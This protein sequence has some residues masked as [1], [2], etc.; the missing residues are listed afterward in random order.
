MI[1]RVII[2]SP[3][4]LLYNSCRDKSKNP[5]KKSTIEMMNSINRGIEFDI[6]EINSLI[7]YI[8]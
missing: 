8:R 7:L 2:R 1:D 5:K 6:S 3:G 4:S